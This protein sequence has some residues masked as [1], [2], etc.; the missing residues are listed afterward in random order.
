MS[1]T[2]ISEL[3]R[4]YKNIYILFDNDKA[5]LEDGVKLSKQTGFINLVLPE[6]E[7]GKDVSDLF[8]VKGEVIFKEVINKLFKKN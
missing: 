4:R 2:A 1:K 6:F 5:G 7:G 3:K 8:K